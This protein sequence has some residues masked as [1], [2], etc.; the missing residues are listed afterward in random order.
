MADFPD[1]EA[2]LVSVL[3]SAMYPNGAAAAPVSGGAIRVFRGWPTAAQLTQD[4]SVNVADV[5]VSAVPGTCRNT[6]RWGLYSFELMSQSSLTVSAT[7][8]TATFAGV[9][10]AFDLAGVLVAG[11]PYVYQAQAGDSAELVAAALGDLVRQA[12]IC[13][14]TGATITVPGAAEVIARVAQAGATLC[15]WARQEMDFGVS[16]WS[17]SPAMRDLVGDVSIQA[18]AP[19]AFLNLAD[20]T[21]A[22]LRFRSAENIDDDQTASVYRRNLVYAAEYA[23]TIQTAAT[24]ML[25]GELD[26]NG[27]VIVA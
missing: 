22:R 8:N 15:E 18:L 7:G 25:F 10:A 26:L 3:L 5:G 2:A 14:V 19:V 24:R 12:Q 6:T 16:I 4:R 13:W 20:G 23:T 9:P 17:P 27:S 1:V 21:S 11:Q